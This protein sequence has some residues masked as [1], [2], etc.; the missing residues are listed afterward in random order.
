MRAQRGG[1]CNQHGVAGG[2]TVVI[3]DLLEVVG[4]NV[5][6]RCRLL[7]AVR[8]DQGAARQLEKSVALQQAGEPVSIGLLAQALLQVELCK[9]Q[10]G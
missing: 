4:V 6:Q 9:H 8:R 5:Q 10:H 1:Q 2:V 7:L 3:V